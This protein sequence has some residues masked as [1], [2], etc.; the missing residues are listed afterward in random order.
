MIVMDS[1]CD[2]ESE[3]TGGRG[4]NGP[5]ERGKRLSLLPTVRTS[6]GSGREQTPLL[7]VFQSVAELSMG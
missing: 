4:G 2:G 1:V 5:N 3:A 6:S 7:A